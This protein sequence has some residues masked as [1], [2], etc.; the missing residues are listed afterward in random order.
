MFVINT[1]NNGC[2]W[3]ILEAF[4]LAFLEHGVYFTYLPSLLASIQTPYVDITPGNHI[5]VSNFE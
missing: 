1:E 4:A 5:D 2:L 3:S